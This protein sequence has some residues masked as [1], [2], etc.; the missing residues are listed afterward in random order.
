MKDFIYELVETAYSQDMDDIQPIEVDRDRV[1][2]MVHDKKAREELSASSHHRNTARPK[3]VPVRVV[4]L[5]IAA[6][7]VLAFSA[8]AY[9]TTELIRSMRS[10]TES[11]LYVMQKGEIDYFKSA[12]NN[13][14]TPIPQ[15]LMYGDLEPVL[16]QFS[17]PVGQTVESSG[18]TLTLE[19]VA[20]DDSFI[21]VFFTAVYDKP[22]DWIVPGMQQDPSV[23]PAEGVV[24]IP[25]HWVLSQALPRLYETT[26]VYV[27]ESTGETTSIPLTESEM[28]A[29][30]VDAFMIDAQTVK[31][32]ARWITPAE[33]PDVFSLSM[34]IAGGNHTGDAS[35]EFD[36]LIDKSAPSKLTRRAEPQILTFDTVEGKRTLDLRRVTLSPFGGVITIGSQGTR[37]SDNIQLSFE[38]FVI[39]DDKGNAVNLLRSGNMDNNTK[40]MAGLSP[41]SLSISFIP[42]LPL[43]DDNKEWTNDD[44]I[45]YRVDDFETKIMTSSLGGFTL[46]S[47]D[48]DSSMLTWVFKPFGWSPELIIFP[49]MENTQFSL[50]GRGAHVP[51]IDRAT[52]NTIYEIDY[53]DL[54]PKEIAAIKTFAVFYMGDYFIDEKAAI[55]VPTLK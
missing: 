23:D 10:E 55:S 48:I 20:V 17:A 19:A 6:A 31:L 15:P 30:A 11:V 25:A 7:I 3:K 44:A 42:V 16:S 50:H 9:G 43:W 13:Q 29:G 32:M 18:M 36:L 52:G 8:L 27:D 53:Y 26:C 49:R 2:S 28:M 39:T 54:T 34:A 38:D 12:K 4:R 37:D 14:G 5:L 33:L 35:F 40:I 24:I 41:E 45:A 22:L 47:F 46:E 1:L 21:N 51:R